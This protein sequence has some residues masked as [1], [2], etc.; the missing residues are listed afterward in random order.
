ML[1]LLYLG[2]S[3]YSGS[4]F[5]LSASTPAVLSG[6]NC[7]S[8]KERLQDCFISGW[9]VTESCPGGA[10]YAGVTCECT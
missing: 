2:V 3:S 7:D 1:W 8:N 6:V 9:E 10:E 4:E 5:G